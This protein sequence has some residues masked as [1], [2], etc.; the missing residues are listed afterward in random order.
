ML[1]LTRASVDFIWSVI[2]YL[3]AFYTDIVDL[4]QVTLNKRFYVVGVLIPCSI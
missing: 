3:D 1:L 2:D 4:Y